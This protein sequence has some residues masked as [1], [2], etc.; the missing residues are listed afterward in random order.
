MTKED[1]GN[2]KKGHFQGSRVKLEV[3][4]LKEIKPWNIGNTIDL[5]TL[6]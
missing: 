1:K 3:E 4:A 6:I 5:S 2:E